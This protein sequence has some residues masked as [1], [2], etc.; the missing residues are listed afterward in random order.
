MSQISSLVGVALGQEC[1]RAA[2]EALNRR[3]GAWKFSPEEWVPD[4]YEHLERLGL[5]HCAF[6]RSD[7]FSP[8]LRERE[9]SFTTAGKTAASKIVGDVRMPVYVSFSFHSA[10][11]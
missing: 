6:G 11:H 1:Y 10:L 8:I 4:E 3:S 2:L 9:I 5:V 7:A